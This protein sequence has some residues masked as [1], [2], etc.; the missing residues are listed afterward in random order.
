MSRPCAAVFH[1]ATLKQNSKSRVNGDRETT[2]GQ[3]TIW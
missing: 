1:A 2:E 3:R